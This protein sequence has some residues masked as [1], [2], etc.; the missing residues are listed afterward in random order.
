MMSNVLSSLSFFFSS[1]HHQSHL[2]E[3]HRI[4]YNADMI[5]YN[6][7]HGILSFFFFIL[8][9]QYEAEHRETTQHQTT[10]K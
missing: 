1:L 8:F 9:A 10:R 4:A 5:S 2:V 3:F 6:N 7:K